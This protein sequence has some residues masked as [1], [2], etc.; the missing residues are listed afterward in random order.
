VF[1]EGE[2]VYNALVGDVI[3][4]K[5]ILVTIGYESADLGFVGFPEAAPSRLPVGRMR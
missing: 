2:A 1:T 5:F 3:K 4:E